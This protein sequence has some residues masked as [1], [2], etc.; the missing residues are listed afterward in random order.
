MLDPCSLEDALALA[1]TKS[2]KKV[3]RLEDNG[4]YTTSSSSNNF[5][6]AIDITIEAHTAVFHHKNGA[7]GDGPII[8]VTNGSSVTLLGGTIENATG[9][10]G[11]GI[12][13]DSNSTLYIQGTTI[14]G[15]KESA[16]DS[17]SCRLTIASTKLQNNSPGDTNSS[18]IHATGGAIVMYQSSLLQNRGGE[19]DIGGGANFQIVGNA[20]LNNGDSNGFNAG[21]SILTA[22]NS[23][24]RFDF[25][26]I[27]ANKSQ[28][29]SGVQCIAGTFTAQNNI[30]W[31]NSGGGPL[32]GTCVHDY[33]FIGPG[34]TYPINTDGGHN[35]ATD[36]K[37]ISEANDP[38]LQAGSPAIKAANPAADLTGIAAKDI[39]G[40]PRLAPADCGADQTH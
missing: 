32:S 36:P 9:T 23:T 28:A 20:F 12:Q 22:V 27:V 6:V 16:I 31:N 21:V 29:A 3:I 7:S 35:K 30:I 17:S 1:A 37:L 14:Q 38:H 33:S 26:T 4:T 25:N 39:D 5:I 34:V 2:A 24:N 19:L 40:D 18:A 13:C 11:D 8:K 10:G 15:N